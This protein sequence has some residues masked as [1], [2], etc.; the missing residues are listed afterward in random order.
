MK[1]AIIVI[2]VLILG[3]I[4]FYFYKQ[5]NVLPTPKETAIALV[6]QNKS[7]QSGTATITPTEDGRVLV[8]LS[9]SGE[10]AT[11]TEPA[12]IHKGTCANLGEVVYDLDTI[13]N[14]EGQAYLVETDGRDTLWEDLVKQLPLAINVHAGEDQPEIAMYLACGEVRL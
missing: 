8:K 12:H 3:A 10:S 2:L 11:A 6:E 5:N 4:G 13:K 7:G 14:G 9:I 1:T